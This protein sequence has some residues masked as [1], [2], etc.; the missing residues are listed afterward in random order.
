M[1][2]EP[3]ERFTPRIH[4][5]AFVH[6]GAYVIGEV[7]LSQGAS[8]WP[9]AVLRGDHGA[10][11]VGPRTNIQDGCVA[12]GTEGVSKT[13]LGAECT[14]GHRAVLHGCVIA[15]HCL[16]GMGAV[17][18]DNVELGEWS[19]V[20]AGALVTANKKF[21]PRSFLLGSPARRIREVSAKEMES[22][23]YSWRAYQDLLR[24]YGR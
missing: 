12:H 19:L 13:V 18:L 2:I 4:P 11:I 16:I 24:R 9:A 17:L 20:G 7:E 15:P 23:D 21:P 10:V 22:I 5:E 3:F 8:V 1:S 6:P 14:V